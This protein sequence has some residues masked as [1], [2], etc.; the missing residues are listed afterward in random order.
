MPRAPR[1]RSETGYYHVTLR[2]NGKQNLFETDTD[3]TAL[4]D[5]VRSSFT[6]REISLIAWCLMSNHIHLVIDDP[7]DHISEALHRVTT[8]YAAYLNHETGHTGH[9]FEG[10]YRSVPIRDDKQLLAAV[11]YVHDNPL[12]GMGVSPGRYPWCSYSEY[13]SGASTY[14]DIGSLLDMLG[15]VQ[16]FTA[17]SLHED[18]EPYRPAFRKY[19]EADE[20][21]QVAR[22][23][24]NAFGCTATSIKELPKETRDRVLSALCDGG[25][26]IAHVQRLTGIGEWT[27]R[28]AVGRIA[29]RSSNR[30]SQ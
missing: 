8:T 20:R 29:R 23:V 14:A 4:L 24:F 25:I 17:I 10:R 15:G 28:K 11:R 19:A 3:R 26:S 9:V 12:R 2:G 30:T 5:A 22:S 6:C 7:H 13:A 27:I 21:E 18:P 1:Q 16:G